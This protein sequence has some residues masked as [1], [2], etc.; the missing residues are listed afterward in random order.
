[1]VDFVFGKMDGLAYLAPEDVDPL[2][3]LPTISHG[4]VEFFADEGFFAS[5][6]E[7]P[8]DLKTGGDFPDPG[9]FFKGV[10]LAP[11][12][13]MTAVVDT[14]MASAEDEKAAKKAAKKAARKEEKKAAKKKAAKALSPKKT[15]TA[16]PKAKATTATTAKPKAKATT[17]TV[18]KPKAKATTT[19]KAA[20]KKSIASRKRP[21]PAPLTGTEVTEK[22]PKTGS[23][24]EEETRVGAAQRLLDV[25]AEEFVPREELEKL[26]EEH[27]N[28]RK[29]TVPKEEHEG[30]LKQLETLKAEVRAIQTMV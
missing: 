7:Q 28:R 27:E 20:A 6:E 24:E 13:A 22:K 3:G 11:P 18:A 14:V 5:Q 26:K 12:P 21:A 4:D 8:V 23:R 1:L 9:R 16:K 25:L 19:A 29:E 10:K 17:A 30:V 2:T 15:T